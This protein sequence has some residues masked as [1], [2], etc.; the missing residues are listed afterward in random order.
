MAIIKEIKEGKVNQSVVHTFEQL[1][2]TGMQT[3]AK[4][5][6]DFFHS[7]M[8]QLK[9]RQATEWSNLDKQYII[10]LNSFKN[11]FEI[12]LEYLRD[13]NFEEAKDKM[14]S[15]LS[16]LL[17]FGPDS[18]SMELSHEKNIFYSFNKGK[19][20]FFITH[21]I[22]NLELDDDEV[23]ISVFIEKTKQPSFSGSLD[24][25]IEFMKGYL[26]IPYENI[27]S[28]SEYELSY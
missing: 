3:S 16:E 24:Q 8:V 15:S 11:Q 5:F 6:A 12:N 18:F 27:S 20:S 4:M 1:N 17:V 2:P 10:F 9:N 14:K 25:G 28:L 21:S 23:I 7:Q 22:D 26:T 19:Y 13:V